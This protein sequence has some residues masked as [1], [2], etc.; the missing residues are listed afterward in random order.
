MPSFFETTPNSHTPDAALRDALVWLSRT[1]RGMAD[2]ILLT[3]PGRLHRGQEIELYSECYRVLAE[4]GSLFIWGSNAGVLGSSLEC[5]LIYGDLTHC[6][7]GWERPSLNTDVR[8]PAFGAMSREMPPS[9]TEWALRAT[10]SAPGRLC[11]DLFPRA[12]HIAQTVGREIGCRVLTVAPVSDLYAAGPTAP[13]FVR[14]N[15]FHTWFFQALEKSG[16]CLVWPGKPNGAGYA[17]LKVGGVEYYAHRVAW[18]LSHKRSIPEGM[19][20]GHAGCVDKRCCAPEHLRLVT[21]IGNMD[22][23]WTGKRVEV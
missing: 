18:M 16:K 6:W 8:L 15:A 2:T 14:D 17:R 11:L 3:L 19:E 20:V 1:P 13:A 22:E 5:Q 23:R 7:G 21:R 9:G 4:N 10:G 12:P